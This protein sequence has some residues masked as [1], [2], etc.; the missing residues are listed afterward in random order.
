MTAG[1]LNTA[2]FKMSRPTD[3]P[4]FVEARAARTPAPGSYATG[5]KCFLQYQLCPNRSPVELFAAVKVSYNWQPVVV[6]IIL[7]L[8]FFMQ[9]VPST[10]LSRLLPLQ[11]GFENF[12]YISLS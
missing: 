11:L 8:T 5:C 10:T 12:H 3:F 9:A 6:L 1:L 7:N 2:V 4:N